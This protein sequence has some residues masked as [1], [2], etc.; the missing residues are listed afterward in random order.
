MSDPVPTQPESPAEVP[1]T[2][3]KA[4]DI[5][6]EP[7][8]T[9]TVEFWKA[10]A[11]ENEK[12][13][14]ENAAKAIEHDKWVEA[15][16]SEDQRRAEAQ[17]AIIARA[18]TAE[19]ERDQLREAKGLDDYKSELSEKTGIPAKVL[20]GGSREELDEHAAVLKP[21]FPER[22]AGAVPTEGRAV[23]TGTGDPAQQ[24]ADIIRNA[25]R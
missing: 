20:R 10:K 1:V 22:K 18:E 9:E 12:R 7:K 14:K 23:T 6:A 15:Q 4:D 16:K 19:R 2:E 25:R 8:P 21:L 24:F 17:A 13:A 3:P 11:R 5:T